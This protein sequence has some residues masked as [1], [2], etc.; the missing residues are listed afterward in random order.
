M[1]AY[2]KRL[3]SRSNKLSERFTGAYKKN[4]ERSRVAGGINTARR[5]RALGAVGIDND[6]SDA[7]VH[8]C[9]ESRSTGIKREL[10]TGNKR[11]EARTLKIIYTGMEADFFKTTTKPSLIGGSEGGVVFT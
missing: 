8:H 1:T 5:Q 3:C 9:T 7:R 4:F 2:S 6:D 11:E 10:S